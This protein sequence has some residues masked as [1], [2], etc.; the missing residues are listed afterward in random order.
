[1]IGIYKKNICFIRIDMHEN[2]HC[3]AI[4]DCW[5]DKIDHQSFPYLLKISEEY[6]VQR[7]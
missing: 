4:I 2:M 3:A 7:K 1:M 6:A 5:M